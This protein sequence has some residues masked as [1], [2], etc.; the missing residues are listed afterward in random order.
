MVMEPWSS[1]VLLRWTLLFIPYCATTAAA[2]VLNDGR[3]GRKQMIAGATAVAVQICYVMAFLIFAGWGNIH[4]VLPPDANDDLSGHWLAG[5]ARWSVLVGS[6]SA[7]PGEASEM[8][9]RIGP[10]AYNF[11]LSGQRSALV[12]HDEADGHYCTC[13]NDSCSGKLLKLSGQLRLADVFLRPLIPLASCLFATWTATVTFGATFWTTPYWAFFGVLFVIGALSFCYV[14]VIAMQTTVAPVLLLARNLQRRAARIVLTDLVEHHRRLILDAEEDDAAQQPPMLFGE[15]AVDTPA[16]PSTAVGRPSKAAMR[17]TLLRR[18]TD[19]PPTD[20]KL[21]AVAFMDL[22]REFCAV[23]KQQL[24]HLSAGKA[25]FLL[26]VVVEVSLVLVNV[27]AGSCIPLWHVFDIGWQ[28]SVLLIDL[29]NFAVA[30]TQV[31]D[32]VA[33]YREARD[34]L[35]EIVARSDAL[36][37]EPEP[38][39]LGEKGRHRYR[40]REARKTAARDAERMIASCMDTERFKGRFIGFA[41][42]FTVVRTVVA[43][44]ISAALGLWSLLAGTIFITV[45]VS[46]GATRRLQRS[47]RRSWSQ[48]M[49]P[50]SPFVN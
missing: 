14:T 40:D 48:T 15:N 29:V 18:P 43:T 23:W 37:A 10:N 12:Q 6:A 45:Q 8:T 25:A 44:A 41:V 39:M 19:A 21:S 32:I 24:A 7:V 38:D 2:V 4:K 1:R 36:Q 17:G 28:M 20:E 16:F 35:R 31:E 34:E 11:I 49:C 3:F 26:N 9:D 42:D 46:A 27:I 30:N 50:D 22:H 5:A 13:G 47:S 33:L